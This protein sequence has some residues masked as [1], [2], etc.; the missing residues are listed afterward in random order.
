MKIRNLI[1]VLALASF[2][3]GG[4]LFAADEKK[5][6]PVSKQAGCCARAEAKGEKCTHECCVEAAKAGNNCERCKGSGKIEKK[7]EVK[8]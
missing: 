7:E 4:S 2:V 5:E 8:K 6:A 3:A 1:A